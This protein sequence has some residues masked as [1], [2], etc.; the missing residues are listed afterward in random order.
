MSGIKKDPDQTLLEALGGVPEKSED[1]IRKEDLPSGFTASKAIPKSSVR[2][3]DLEK[4]SNDAA[5]LQEVAV[6]VDQIQDAA[7]GS[8]D[9]LAALIMPLIFEF[10]FPPVFQAV[11]RWL[12]DYVHKPRVFPQL[13]LGLPRGFGKTTLVKIFIVYCILFTKKKFILIIS[14]KATLAENILSDVMDMLE[15]GNIKRVFGHWKLGI[16]KDTQSLKKFGFRGRDITIAAIG[17]QTS[18]RGLNI[19]NERPDVMIFEDIQS[20]ECADSE[21]QSTALENWM[22]GTAMKAK[23]P[24]GCMF[25]FV[26]NMYP[27]K[28]SILRRLKHNPRWTKFI[29]GGIREDGTSLWE[30]LQPIEQLMAEFENDLAA[31]KPEIFY[32]EVLNDENASANNLIDLSKLPD[33]PH[34]EGD[35]P[36]GNFIIIDPATDKLGADEV[37][38]GYFE[39]HDATPILMSVKEGRFSPGDTIRHALDYAL[40]NNCRLIAVEANAYQYS[41]LYWFEF[42]CQQMGIVGIEAV[43]VYS[44]TRAKNARILEMFKGYAAGELFVHENAKAPVHMQITSFNALRRD[45]TDGLLDLLTYAPKVVEE[46]G[47]YVVASNIIESQEFDSLEVPEMNSPF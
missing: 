4:H 44:G 40:N 2:F 41:L 43:P 28:W 25:L 23:S 26:A 32:A 8:L 30:D 46:Y 38:V 22:V 35:I 3:S 10:G 27:T 34:Q 42:I 37:S 19:K 47:E 20:R 9:F 7:K 12:L 11:W 18:L 39:I 33:V 13:A 16:E 24:K 36:A 45:N 17:A 1:K 6:S 21:V 5:D 15:E 31:G 14:A 29:A